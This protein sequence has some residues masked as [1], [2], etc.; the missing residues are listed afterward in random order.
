MAYRTILMFGPPGSGKGTW[1]D[2]LGRIPGFCHVSSGDMLRALS[3]D[4]ALG[5]LALSY[6]R[7]GQLVPDECTIQL[8]REHMQGLV[9]AG[10]FD[11]GAHVVV[12]DGLP[13]TL[14]QAE[15]VDADLD[16]RLV[17][18]LD[19]PDRE[20]LVKRLHGRAL[21]DDRVDDAGEEVIRNRFQVYDRQTEGTLAHFPGDRLKKIDV[22]QRPDRILLDISRAVVDSLGDPPQM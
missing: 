1:G 11:P 4:S 9:S 19:S 20:R 22:S 7:Q 15:A 2:I 18:L 10:T 8:W 13:R 14:A 5:A 17:L 6:I 16:V 3:P 12:L 21:K